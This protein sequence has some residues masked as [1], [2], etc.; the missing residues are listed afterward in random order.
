MNEL[1]TFTYEGNNVRTVQIS[2]EPWW[3]LKDVCDVLGLSSP[4]KVVERLDEDEKGRSLIPTLGGEQEMNIVSE[5]GLYNV[6]LRSD[7]PEAKM[8][9]RW[10]THDVLPAIRSNG[11]YMTDS[12]LRS[13][14]VNPNAFIHEI[15]RRF[16]QMESETMALAT[17]K[18]DLEIKLNE[19]EKFWTIMK[20]NQHFG[21]GWNMRQC[22]SNGRRASAY[23]RQHGYEIGKCKTGDDRFEETNS[24]AFDVLERLFLTKKITVEV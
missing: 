8:F 9:K 5:S 4:H 14:A 18:E 23:S 21:M 6:I 12:K 15:Y 2:G 11:Y 13:T 16:C 10:I 20:F 1:T 7:K 3:V 17:Q 24:Y 22:Q 19:S